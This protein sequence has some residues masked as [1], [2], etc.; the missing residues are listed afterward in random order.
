[1]LEHVISYPLKISVPWVEIWEIHQICP[2]TAWKLVA[3]ETALCLT[4]FRFWTK[5]NPFPE[6]QFSLFSHYCFWSF[7]SIVS[8][9]PWA[10]WRMLM[11]HLCP[12]Q[13]MPLCPCALLYRTLCTD[14]WP[15]WSWIPSTYILGGSVCGGGLCVFWVLGRNVCMRV[16]EYAQGCQVVTYICVITTF[17]CVF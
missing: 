13:C 9:C 3:S 7:R 1:M 5:A 11:H 8:G 14:G 17:I 12:D 2:S 4:L 16:W 10:C 6:R 15:N